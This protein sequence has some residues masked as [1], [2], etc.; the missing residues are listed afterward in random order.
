MMQ[1]SASVATLDA[2][3]SSSAMTP[4]A[5]QD[6]SSLFP[7]SVQN[8]DSFAYLPDAHEN[9][10]L[11]LKLIANAGSDTPTSSPSCRSSESLRLRF[12]RVCSSRLAG[13]L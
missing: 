1:Q 11:Y 5:M 12:G 7:F 3:S 13:M 2:N 4:F 6:W 9:L 8:G 10:T